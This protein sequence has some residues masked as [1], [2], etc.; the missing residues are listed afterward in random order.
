MDLTVNAGL[1]WYDLF[2]K[3][4]PDNGLPLLKDV[5]REGKVMVNG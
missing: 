4:Y 1:N 5:N 2:R 3:S